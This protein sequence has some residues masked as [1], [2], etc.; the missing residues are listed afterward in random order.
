MKDQRKSSEILAS[1][2]I[3]EFFIGNFAKNTYNHSILL[4][5]VIP[6][7]WSLKG[8]RWWEQKFRKVY[9]KVYKNFTTYTHI[10]LALHSW[11]CSGKNMKLMLSN[12]QYVYQKIRNGKNDKNN[13]LYN[14]FLK[15]RYTLTCQKFKHEADHSLRSQAMNK[16]FLFY[17]R[18]N[19]ELAISLTWS[20]P[21]PAR[22]RP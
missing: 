9:D 15:F 2:L 21:R 16:N 3:T 17:L 22:H 6:R 20:R 18:D 8:M 13:V 10:Y 12:T 14:H 5:Y 19:Q 11:A 4:D 7:I 1:R